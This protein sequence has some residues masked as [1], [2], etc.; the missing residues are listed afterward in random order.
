MEFNHNKP[1]L[2]WQQPN[3]GFANPDHQNCSKS[4]ATTQAPDERKSNGG[5]NLAQEI[6]QT[7]TTETTGASEITKQN[8]DPNS[9][10]K[11]ES[12]QPPEHI[13]KYINIS[14]ALKLHDEFDKIA[15]TS[16]QITANQFSSCPYIHK[17]ITAANGSDQLLHN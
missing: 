3:S 14:T 10:T 5:T 6:Q 2:E 9:S 15:S 1:N 16:G 7:I 12:P 4:S 11:I 17:F 8:G 13:T